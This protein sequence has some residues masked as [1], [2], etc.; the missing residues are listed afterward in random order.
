MNNSKHKSRNTI[1]FVVIAAMWMVSLACGSSVATLDSPP[2]FEEISQQTNRANLSAQ[3]TMDSVDVHYEEL[4]RLSIKDIDEFWRKEFPN[5]WPTRRYV[6]PDSFHAYT[7]SMGPPIDCQVASWANNALYCPLDMSISW[8]EEWFRKVLAT[9]TREQDMAPIA[10]LAHEWGHHIQ[11][12]VGGPRTSI[13]KELQA[14][15]YAGLY[16]SYVEQGNGLIRLESGD[17]REAGVTFFTIG[18]RNFRSS[19]WFDDN[20]HGPPVERVMAFSRGY[21]SSDANYCIAY[22]SYRFQPELAV[23]SYRFNV[24]PGFTNTSE[25]G[26]DI[27]QLEG[28]GCT[29]QIRANPKLGKA[30][31]SRQ[32]DAVKQTWFGS[33]EVKEMTSVLNTSFAVYDNGTAVAQKYEQYLPTDKMTVHGILFLHIKPN[34]GGLVM[35]VFADGKAPTTIKAWS[36]LEKCL[37]MTLYGLRF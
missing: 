34:G 16:I 28:L 33:T 14:D 12:L 35:D 13:G 15:C 11:Y 26:S 4:I 7:P 21:V 30:T 10:I 27:T 19:A 2:A 9:F 17:V 18:D 23:G 36:G 8:D 6:S 1:H 32:F 25:S 31:A 37:Y 3:A 5:I 29:I 24:S 20:A 22:N